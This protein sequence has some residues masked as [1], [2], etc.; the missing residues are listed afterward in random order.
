LITE[1]VTPALASLIFC[2]ASSS[3]SS[4]STLMVASVVVPVASRISIGQAG[5]ACEV[6][7]SVAEP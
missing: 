3:V 6:T 2:A 1:A 5:S 7:R 4:A